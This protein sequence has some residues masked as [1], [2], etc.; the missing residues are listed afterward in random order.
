[1][2]QLSALHNSYQLSSRTITYQ[3]YKTFT[4]EQF[5]E[6]IRSARSYIEGG[7]L[8]SLQHVIEK[9]I[10]QF[11]PINKIVLQVIPNPTWHLNW[12][13]VLSKDV[14]LKI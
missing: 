4:E 3:S 8:T 1:M 10:Y 11:A 14:D 9:K 13:K 7:M 12:E 6:A 5:K 2:W